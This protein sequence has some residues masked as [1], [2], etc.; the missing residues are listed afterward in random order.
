MNGS[1]ERVDDSLSPLESE[2]VWRGWSV[3]LTTYR[4]HVS[5]VYDEVLDEVAGRI[6]VVGSIGKADIGALLMW[7]RLRADT[8]WARKLSDMH[9]ADV[10]AATAPAVAVVRDA[11]VLV[12]DAAR[13]GRGLLSP[14]PGFR[15][16][17]ALASA[18]LVA[19]ASHR[20]AVYDRHAHSGLTL[21]GHDLSPSQGA[22]AAT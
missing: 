14:L 9:D 18:V 3:G 1:A 15:V 11:D 6:A 13:A 22:T 19:V 10:R 4:Q 12:V 17:D 8:R 16:G 7:K 5:R 2:S 21:L 20:M